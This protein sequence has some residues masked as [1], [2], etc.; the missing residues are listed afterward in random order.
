MGQ[1][2]IMQWCSWRDREGGAVGGRGGGG[3][4]EEKE[5]KWIGY[6]LSPRW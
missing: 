4:K 5:D 2:M 1:K 3:G 6:G